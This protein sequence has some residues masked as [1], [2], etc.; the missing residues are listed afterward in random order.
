MEE[1]SPYLENYLEVHHAADTDRKEDGLIVQRDPKTQFSE[2]FV[3]AG[4]PERCVDSI[5]KW[6]EGCRFNGHFGHIPLRWHAA[7]NGNE[8]YPAVRGTR[9]AGV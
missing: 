9:D 8:E 2:G 3:I 4:D 1:A 5:Q 7:G 6:R